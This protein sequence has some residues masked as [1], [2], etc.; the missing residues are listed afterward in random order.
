[1]SH[2]ETPKAAKDGGRSVGDL[3]SALESLT[4][5]SSASFDQIG[6]LCQT[7]LLLLKS[8]LVY[9]SPWLAAT[10]VEI[11]LAIAGRASAVT[12]AFA[13]QHGCLPLP[14]HMREILDARA[15]FIRSLNG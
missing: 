13:E 3:Q 8:P 15:H 7:L 4:Q 6:A 1:M 2:S 14:E 11:M 10:Q 9:E 5:Q 12:D